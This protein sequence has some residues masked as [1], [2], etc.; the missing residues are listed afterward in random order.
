MGHGLW[1]SDMRAGNSFK[2]SDIDALVTGPDRQLCCFVEDRR[3]GASQPPAD[4]ENE[5]DNLT[6][7]QIRWF[8]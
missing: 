7:R 4:L 6:S 5:L 1:V 3:Y 8:S 2:V